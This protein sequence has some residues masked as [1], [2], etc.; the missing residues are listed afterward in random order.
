MSPRP[1]CRP[2]CSRLGVKV[3]PP[4]SIR[5]SPRFAHITVVGVGHSEASQDEEAPAPV[6]RADLIRREQSR[7]DASTHARQLAGDNVEAEIDMADDVL[8][9]EPLGPDVADDAGD[10]RPEV[11][12]IGGAELLAGGRERLARVARSDDV[13][14]STPERAVEGGEVVPDRSRM[15]ARVLHPGHES[16]RREGIPLDEAHSAIA[17]LGDG[18]AEVQAGDAGAEGEAE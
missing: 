6:R 18:D 3:Q 13:H 7:F 4:S 9:E 12:G 5:Q 2:T 15:K 16:G 10:V 11:P 8:E 17:G 14:R 1:Y